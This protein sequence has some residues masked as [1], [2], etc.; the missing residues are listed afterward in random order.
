MTAIAAEGDHA[1]TGR[2]GQ[3]ENRVIHDRLADDRDQQEC[4]YLM[5]LWWQLGMYYREVTLDQLRGFEQT[6]A[7]LLRGNARPT[8]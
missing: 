7:L 5:R 3:A 2:P 6:G 8:P 4:R 1:S